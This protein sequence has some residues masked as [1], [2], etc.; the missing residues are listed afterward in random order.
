MNLCKVVY[1]QYKYMKATWLYS[2]KGGGRVKLMRSSK[3]STD[4]GDLNTLIAYTMSKPIKYKNKSKSK[5]KDESN[6]D[7]ESEHFNF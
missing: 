6:S 4:G 1:A 7:D 5:A 3:R 2:H